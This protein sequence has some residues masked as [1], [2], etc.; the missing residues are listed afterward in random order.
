MN[1]K[2]K[3]IVI[4]IICFFL[5]FII[6]H[7]LPLSSRCNFKYC[8]VLYFSIATVALIFMAIF[9]A[10]EEKT[11]YQITADIAR[12]SSKPV[13]LMSYVAG[14]TLLLFIIWFMYT[15]LWLPTLHKEFILW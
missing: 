4:F 9:I 6:D 5:I 1:L 15:K 14:L 12:I 10:K 3:P 8:S 13:L 11:I 2:S 7:A